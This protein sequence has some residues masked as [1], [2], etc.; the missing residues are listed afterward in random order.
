MNSGKP[1]GVRNVT[2]VCHK[3]VW[4]TAIRSVSLWTFVWTQLLRKWK[5][6]NREITCRRKCMWHSREMWR[7]AGG[8][9]PWHC[10]A[11]PQYVF[12]YWRPKTENIC[13]YRF[14]ICLPR[15]CTQ[16]FV[17]DVPVTSL[18]VQFREV[19]Y[20]VEDLQICFRHTRRIWTDLPNIKR[21]SFLL[22][23]Y[24][25]FMLAEHKIRLQYEKQS[26]VVF[27]WNNDCFLWELYNT[28][29]YTVCLTA[30]VINVT[31]DDVY[32][33]AISGLTIAVPALHMN[34]GRLPFSA[35]Y[36]CRYD[37]NIYI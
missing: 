26:D 21:N 13:K 2:T 32:T 33:T 27:M 9:Y 11:W 18:W 31:T 24:V 23:L 7:A 3:C 37:T 30:E 8:V 14:T 1:V 12:L 25:L 4:T 29:K 16:C 19:T 20:A 15:S 34:Y 10:L 5:R 22:S 6:N 35:I 36:H 17:T 28:H